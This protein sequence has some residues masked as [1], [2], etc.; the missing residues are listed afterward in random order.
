MIHIRSQLDFQTC[1]LHNNFL[2]EA[3]KLFEVHQVKVTKSDKPAEILYHKSFGNN[4]SVDLI[5]FRLCI[6]FLSK[7]D[8][9]SGLSTHTLEEL[10]TRHLTRLSP[11]CAVNSRLMMML[12]E[13]REL[14][15]DS[16]LWKPSSSLEN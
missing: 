3:A 2:P 11:W 1:P 10:A 14:S 13:S 7:E 8:V 15:L 9:L 6:L 16:N 4:V 12:S 5:C